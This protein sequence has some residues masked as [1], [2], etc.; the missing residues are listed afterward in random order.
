MK[1][2]LMKLTLFHKLFIDLNLYTPKNSRKTVEVLFCRANKTRTIP[3]SRFL[4]ILGEV[5]KEHFR[6]EA[7][8]YARV[9]KYAKLYIL[10]NSSISADRSAYKVWNDTL[11]D[12]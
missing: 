11:A 2:D 6:S 10:Q 5:G 7:D 1:S 12:E 3:F 4:S 8:Q 9:E